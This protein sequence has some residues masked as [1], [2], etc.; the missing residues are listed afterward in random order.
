MR[1]ALERFA[2]RM[3]RGEA[4]YGGRLVRIL[5]LPLEGAWRLTTHARNRRHDRSGA[6]S[7]TGLRIVSVGNLAVGGTGKTPMAAWIAAR[8]QT[9]GA[10]PVLLLRG[11]GDDEIALHRSW[12]PDVPVEVG[13]D[14]VKAAETARAQGAD[15]AVLDDGFQHRGLARSLDVVLLAVEDPLPGP[16][17]P[18]GP[19]REP[20]TA[21]RR[22]DLV[23]LTRRSRSREEAE[24]QLARLR[25]AGVLSDSAD[26]ACVRLESDSLRTL[27]DFA[28]G[29]SARVERPG[30]SV[31][32]AGGG[33]PTDEE[34]V[35]GREAV[36]L[37]AIARPHAFRD[38]VEALTHSSVELLAYPDHHSY[39]REDVRRARRKAGSRPI[40]V[41]EKDAVKLEDHVEALGET[42]VVGQRLDW[43]WGRDDVIRRLEAVFGPNEEVET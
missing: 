12:N 18:R 29:R 33:S 41:T 10:R 23:I 13:S 25:S 32:E 40:F 9:M 7:V 38:T 6:R 30:R 11:Y 31:V 36:A 35:E 2:W 15:A 14:R 24:G 37:T 43:D 34:G 21:L 16:L 3:W 8:L 42:W 5:L 1:G 4:G 20:M 27:S 17:L 39:S 19:Y 28:S 22:A 26:T